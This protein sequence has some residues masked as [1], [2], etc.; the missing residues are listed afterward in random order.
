MKHTE[1]PTIKM[2]DFL[3]WFSFVGKN[4]HSACDDMP[5]DVS[6]WQL[7]G[8]C[9]TLPVLVC[10]KWQASSYVLI[11]CTHTDR[12]ASIMDLPSSLACNE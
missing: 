9:S 10:F 2:Y 5:R 7:R 8:Y 12:P 6:A 4:T 11:K 3:Q 1:P